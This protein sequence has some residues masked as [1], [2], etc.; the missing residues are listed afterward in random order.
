M[1]EKLFVRDTLLESAD[2]LLVDDFLMGLLVLGCYATDRSSGNK[3][4]PIYL[5]AH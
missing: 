2:S 5:G 4:L 3:L 1:A